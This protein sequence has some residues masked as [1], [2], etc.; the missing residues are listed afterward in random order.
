MSTHNQATNTTV[1]VHGSQTGGLIT[2]VLQGENTS[3]VDT[4]SPQGEKPE[5]AHSSANT[6]NHHEA[7]NTTVTVHGKQTGG[8]ITGVNQG[9]ITLHRVDVNVSDGEAARECLP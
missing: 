3:S 5:K 1:T 8:S 6:T 9:D 7:S 4:A 2:G